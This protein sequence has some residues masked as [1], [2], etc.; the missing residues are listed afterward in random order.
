MVAHRKI[1]S[2][3]F[4][5]TA[6][7]LA[8]C[9]AQGDARSSSGKGPDGTAQ[10]AGASAAPQTSSTSE[11]GPAALPPAAL[12]AWEGYARQQCRTMGE[13]FVQ[14]RFTRLAKGATVDR[15]GRGIFVTTDFNGDGK[16]DFIAV[17][18]NQG[19][20]GQAPGQGVVDFI[21]S[22][23]DKYR[24]VEGYS[25][26]FD[27]SMVN[28]RKGRDVVDF[29]GGFF[30]SCG[31][32]TVAVWGWSGDRMDVIERRNSTGQSVDKEGCAVAARTSAPPA[33]NSTFPPIEPGYWAGG[34]SCADAIAEAAELPPDQASLQYLDPKGGT[35]G[36][37]E[38]QR[39]APLGGNSYRL[40]GRDQTEIG[41][42]PGQMDITVKNRTSFTETKY[43]GRY[44]H[45]PTS[46]IPGAIRADFESR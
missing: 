4:I 19:C 37:F 36:R 29:P 13:R 6:F 35:I 46:T 18:A 41:S 5:S 25:G 42:S 15:P 12:A 28:K 17:T 33:G 22:T 44:T 30:G 7:A 14:V 45:C 9:G 2:F 16:P 21:L 10:P 1:G 11:I 20:S 32:V 40:I 27:V 43:G 39:Y 8:A 26:P 31:E 3:A 38:V 24:A 34:V 23:G